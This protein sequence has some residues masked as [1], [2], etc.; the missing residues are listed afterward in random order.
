MICNDDIWTKWMDLLR[1]GGREVRMDGNM[2]GYWL[3]G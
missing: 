3:T 2:Y 1:K